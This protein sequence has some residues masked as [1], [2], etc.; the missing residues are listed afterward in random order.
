MNNRDGKRRLSLITILNQ[1][2]SFPCRYVVYASLLKIKQKSFN[3]ILLRRHLVSLLL[4]VPRH[5]MKGELPIR[6]NCFL[7]SVNTFSSRKTRKTSV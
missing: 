3:R 5:R 1:S 4:I 6:K 2:L 7:T